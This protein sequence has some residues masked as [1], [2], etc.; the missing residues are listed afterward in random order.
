MII[1]IIAALAMVFA[2][3]CLEGWLF[4]LFWNKVLIGLIG[5]SLPIIK[6]WTSVLVWLLI[7]TLFGKS[8]SSSNK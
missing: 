8:Y 5:L 1:V 3:V 7:S 6:Y 2:A 4:M